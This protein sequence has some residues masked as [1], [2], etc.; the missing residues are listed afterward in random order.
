MLWCLIYVGMVERCL[1]QRFSIRA[2]I[3]GSRWR[4]EC[5]LRD[6]GCGGGGSDLS[7]VARRGRGLAAALP[8]A[9]CLAG[10]LPGCY[11]NCLAMH[12]FSRGSEAG[13]RGSRAVDAV[14]CRACGSD[15]A[16]AA[17][18]GAAKRMGACLAA[19][20]DAM[21]YKPFPPPMPCEL[22]SCLR[23]QRGRHRRG[24]V[25]SVRPRP[26]RAVDRVSTAPRSRD[27]CRDN[28]G[29]HQKYQISDLK[30]QTRISKI[31]PRISNIKPN[32]FATI[33]AVH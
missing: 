29:R 5:G 27:Q 20:R 7:R 16:S 4:V 6:D 15:G 10:L 1:A 21:Q 25:E 23:D 24:S 18:A 19:L 28:A 31:K 11:A 9:L 8:L 30:H 13:R 14:R 32:P 22:L 12:V 33:A 3:L 17:V 26:D 2:A